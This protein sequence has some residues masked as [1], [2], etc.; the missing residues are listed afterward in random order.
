MA[1]TLTI[2]NSDDELE[3][4]A[5]FH[6]PFTQPSE[7]GLSKASFT[8]SNLK[9]KASK[10]LNIIPGSEIEDFSDEYSESVL[11]IEFDTIILTAPLVNNTMD[12][13]LPDK[14]DLMHEVKFE[15]PNVRPPAPQVQWESHD[16]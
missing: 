13:D 1:L 10:D 15:E 11:I 8:V 14:S 12:I 3:I 16:L 6:A 2:D 7:A 4:P 9:R 5:E